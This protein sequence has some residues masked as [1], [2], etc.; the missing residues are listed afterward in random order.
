MDSHDLE[1]LRSL[2]RDGRKT[3]AI[4]AARSLENLDLKGALD[5][6]NAIEG[7]AGLVEVSSMVGQSAVV[8]SAAAQVGG[9][10]QGWMA[11]VEDA[12]ARKQKI[13]AIKI[14][15]EHAGVGLREAKDAVEALERRPGLA[16]PS[17][18]AASSG[19]SDQGL[20]AVKDAMR[21]G[22][23]IEA[24]KLYRELK[25]VGLKEAKDAVESMVF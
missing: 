17:P 11:E 1:N 24:I 21:R 22:K 16:S 23:K 19:V 20:E 10:G 7:G 4:A 13:L 18:S 9:S 15:R 6:V 12:L 3:E 5:L 14:Y 2:I 8:Q 25:G